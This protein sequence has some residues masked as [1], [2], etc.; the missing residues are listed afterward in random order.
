MNN[1]DI[2]L[3]SDGLYSEYTGTVMTSILKNSLDN[4][5]INFYIID[6]GISQSD[7]KKIYELKNIK[8]C[9]INFCKYQKTKYIHIYEEKLKNKTYLTPSVLCKLEIYNILKDLDKII[10]LDSDVI[11]RRSLYDFFNTNIDNYSILAATS[12]RK[13]GYFNSGV[14]MLNLKRL[15]DINIDIK[16]LEYCNSVKEIS[17]LLDQEILNNVLGNDVLFTEQF[18]NC[19]CTKKSHYKYNNIEQIYII[20]YAGH[21]C[22]PW[23]NECNLAYYVEEYWKYFCLTPWFKENPG[24][25]IEIMI[26]QKIN[27]LENKLN[28][29]NKL[30]IDKIIKL[31]KENLNI[32]Y[33]INKIVNTIAW[34]IP[35]KK[36]RNNFRAK[37]AIEDQT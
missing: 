24:K 30:Y 21:G 13:K 16:F 7:I 19:V 36:W 15:R 8:N 32:Y 33:Q 26:N 2:C 35:I 10:F 11:V 6:V 1:I 12:A 31:E 14:M 28:N 37:F 34:W 29:E 4:E 5:Y 27:N 3:I 22:K 25:Y 20:H 17:I 23:E 9:S 18:Y